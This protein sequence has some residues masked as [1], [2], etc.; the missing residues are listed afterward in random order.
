MN[1]PLIASR[2]MA[3]MPIA[4]IAL[5][6]FVPEIAMAQE[7]FKDVAKRLEGNLA[8]GRSL[9]LMAMFLVG[10]IVFG[11]GIYLIYKDSKQ[12]NQDHAKKGMIGILVGALLLSVPTVVGVMG[13]T[14]LG[15]SQEAS[16]NINS[17]F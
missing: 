3:A 9:A 14:V 7:E 6:L 16:D 15:S 5:A 1:F 10:L 17:T 4:I 8:A 13:S 2:L 11:T 12:P